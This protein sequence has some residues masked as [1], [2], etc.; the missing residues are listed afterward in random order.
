MSYSQEIYDAARSRIGPCGAALAWRVMPNPEFT[1]LACG[2]RVY[3]YI[4]G[5]KYLLVS[6]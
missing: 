6:Y 5:N 4:G 1:G 2:V 3:F